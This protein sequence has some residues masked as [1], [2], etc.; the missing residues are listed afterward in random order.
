MEILQQ[1]WPITGNGSVLVTCRGENV[2]AQYA[3]VVVEIPAFSL[4][5][6]SQ[7]ILRILNRDITP[8][9]RASSLQL[10]DKLGGLALALDLIAKQIRFRRKTITQF[11]PDYEKAYQ[12]LHRAPKRGIPNSYYS[13]DLETVWKTQFDD[14]TVEAA[15]LISIF[16]YFAP[17]AIPT[18]ILQGFDEAPSGYLFL[19]DS[20]T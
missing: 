3:A 13:K 12:V 20:A 4:E 17:E 5:E 16:C 9:E 8:E 15:A 18:S 6:G 7:L 11:L 10:S 2:A 14:L 1:N 19:K